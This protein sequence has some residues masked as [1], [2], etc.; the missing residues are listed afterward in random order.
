MLSFSYVPF[1]G[2][3]ENAFFPITEIFS[4]I[5][6]GV[7]YE[8]NIC[9]FTSDIVFGSPRGLVISLCFSKD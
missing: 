5:N 9:F 1:T 8:N 4:V 2:F 7:V 6:S 3:L